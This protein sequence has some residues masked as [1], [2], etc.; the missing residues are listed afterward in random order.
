[1][2]GI[3]YLVIMMIS[4]IPVILCLVL[5]FKVWGMTNDVANIKKMLE[6]YIRQ[7]SE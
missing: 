1:M 4:L 3:S 7:K 5:F 2:E 6:E